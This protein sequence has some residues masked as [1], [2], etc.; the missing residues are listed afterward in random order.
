MT[1]FAVATLATRSATRMLDRNAQSG[2]GDR[3]IR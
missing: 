1:R 3:I 2:L